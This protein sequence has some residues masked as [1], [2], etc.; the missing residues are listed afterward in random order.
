MREIPTTGLNLN[1]ENHEDVATG[2]YEADEMWA[3]EMLAAQDRR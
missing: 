2:D 1:L 3:R